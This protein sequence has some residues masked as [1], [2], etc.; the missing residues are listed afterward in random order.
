[1]KPIFKL[2]SKGFSAIEMMVVVAIIAIL[3]MIAIPSSMGR[4]V[5]EQVQ[6]A[7]PLADI[8]KEPV[9]ATWKMSKKLPADNK[10]AGLPA[11]E[12]IVSN[13]ISAVELQDGVIHMT[14]GNKAH[15]KIKGKILSIR[16]AVIEESQI[17]PVAWVCGKA[18]A[19]DKM[20]L[21]GDNKTNISD[22]YLPYLCK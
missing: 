17:V 8:A 19:P 10:E 15:P 20:A 2:K 14:F 21:K 16:P 7:L 22:E 12:L 1:M 5:K 6:A 9:V 11:P 18:K 13:L 4:I 3:A